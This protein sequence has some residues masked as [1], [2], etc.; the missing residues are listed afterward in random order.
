[1]EVGIEICDYS[2]SVNVLSKIPAQLKLI[3]VLCE[4]NIYTL[5]LILRLPIINLRV[6]PLSQD[7][8]RSHCLHQRETG[9]CTNTWSF[10]S[11]QVEC[12]KIHAFFSVYWPELLEIALCFSFPFP[13]PRP[14]LPVRML[15]VRENCFLAFLDSKPSDCKVSHWQLPYIS[16][17]CFPCSKISLLFLLTKRSMSTFACIQNF[18]SPDA[19]GC[20]QCMLILVTSLRVVPSAVPV[21]PELSAAMWGTEPHSSLLS[22]F[23]WW[24]IF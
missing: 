20:G 19:W 22:I 14:C 11:N 21:T 6:S 10:A 2:H 7:D 16:T 18:V 1:M 4:V 9:S 24:T 5:G 8:H 13:L 17:A 15:T 23:Q 12:A 3:H